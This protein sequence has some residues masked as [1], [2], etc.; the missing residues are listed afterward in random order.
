MGLSETITGYA[1]AGVAPGHARGGDRAV[2]TL[3][4]AWFAHEPP[5]PDKP[6]DEGHGA[7]IPSP[8]GQFHYNQPKSCSSTPSTAGRSS[9]PVRRARGPGVTWLLSTS[10]VGNLG[11]IALPAH[12]DVHELELYPLTARPRAAP[13]PAATSGSPATAAPTSAHPARR[14]R[15]GA[16]ARGGA[17]Q[18]LCPG[19]TGFDPVQCDPPRLV[20]IGQGPT[21]AQPPWT[22]DR[23]TYA[24]IV[25][26]ADGRLWYVQS[27]SSRGA[28]LAL[29]PDSAR[30]WLALGRM[31]DGTF[32]ISPDGKD[33]WVVGNG[34][35]WE[36]KGTTWDAG[37][38]P[39]AGGPSWA[40][41]AA[42]GDR[43]L[44]IS[45]GHTLRYSRTQSRPI[46]DRDACPWSC[47][48]ARCCSTPGRRR[49]APGTVRGRPANGSTCGTAATS[50]PRCP[51]L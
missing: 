4:G 14:H 20:H 29:S 40:L 9:P 13:C 1:G 47:R 8:G 27:D 30:T 15:R 10:T 37:P 35:I 16:A 36:L 43:A 12:P 42:L 51:D 2:L 23:D 41:A 45:D 7:L 3:S 22:G 26:G 17:Y 48:T 32:T 33:V 18:M 21:P 44:L 11:W 5:L 38:G 28:W 49:R 6:A 34:V 50:D 19:A 24:R 39:K 25:N 31:P 46:P